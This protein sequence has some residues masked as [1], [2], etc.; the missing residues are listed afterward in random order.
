MK[1]NVLRYKA[2]RCDDIFGG[3]VLNNLFTEN[4]AYRMSQ[5]MRQCTAQHF[6]EAAFNTLPCRSPQHRNTDYVTSGISKQL[7][8]WSHKQVV[9][10][11]IRG[12]HAWS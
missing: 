2:A 5:T 3:P 4:C 9:L 6:S 8:R 7:C 11:H 10:E 12:K 1:L